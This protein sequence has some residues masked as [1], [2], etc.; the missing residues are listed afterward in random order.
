V[1]IGADRQSQ[2]QKDYQKDVEAAGGLYYVAKD[3]TTFVQWYTN[4]FEK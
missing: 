3:L 1:K 4:T 2:A